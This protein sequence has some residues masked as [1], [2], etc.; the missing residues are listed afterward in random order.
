VVPAKACSTGRGEATEPDDIDRPKRSCAET[1]TSRAAEMASE[2]AAPVDHS[3][4]A[5]TGSYAS[6]RRRSQDDRSRLRWVVA[7][8]LTV[9]TLLGGLEMIL[10]EGR[11]ARDARRLSRD[12]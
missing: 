10:A 7:D 12:G 1:S 4:R 6:S 2:D 8:N 3:E 11:L 9:P 5:N